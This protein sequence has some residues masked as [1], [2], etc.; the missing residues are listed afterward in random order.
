MSKVFDDAY[1]NGAAVPVLDVV[2]DFNYFCKWY[3][4][5]DVA[6]LGCI[7][8]YVLNVKSNPGDPG[9][10]EECLNLVV[11]ESELFVDEVCPFCNKKREE[12]EQ[13]D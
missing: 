6:T 10:P 13:V 5:A 3:E 12:R 2:N 11:V 4:L 8:C 1:Q 9:G 7:I